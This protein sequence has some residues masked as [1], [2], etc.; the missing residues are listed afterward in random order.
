M[1][2]TELENA[3]FNLM[4]RAPPGNTE[5]ADSVAD[6]D[7][8]FLPPGNELNDAAGSTLDI[9]DDFLPP[10]KEL[11][12]KATELV[13][14]DDFLPPENEL[15]V[16]TESSEASNSIEN[17]EDQE[18]EDTSLARAEFKKEMIKLH[19]SGMMTDD[20][21]EGILQHMKLDMSNPDDVEFLRILEETLTEIGDD[22]DLRPM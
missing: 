19:E 10:E 6:I 18:P 21:R 22:S 16:D 9:D 14:D 5:P 3:L 8:D 20:I 7:D 11:N 2:D 15:K 4:N 13:I 12:N 17:N 1:S